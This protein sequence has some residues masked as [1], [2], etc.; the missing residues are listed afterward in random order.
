MD[1]A[2]DES[3]NFKD[4]WA[5]D[6]DDSP[7]PVRGSGEGR[8]TSAPRQS[9][10]ARTTGATKGDGRAARAGADFD[11]EAR[12]APRRRINDKPPSGP[13]AV[14]ALL[15]CLAV[16]ALVVTGFIG[17]GPLAG[18]FFFPGGTHK[19]V[20]ATAQG[21]APWEVRSDDVTFIVVGPASPFIPKDPVDHAR[22]I[23]VT[24]EYAGD[25]LRAP[26]VAMS[27]GGVSLREDLGYSQR[28]EG[29]KGSE[30]QRA[31]VVFMALGDQTPRKVTVS[32]RD[33]F[34]DDARN[35]AVTDVPVR[36]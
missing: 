11:D 16:L 20:S 17:R 27:D 21:K 6:D 32:L 22:R 8:H 15:V 36:G 2:R 29:T 14:V 18:R 12:L 23:A 7:P 26:S 25:D 35:L 4:P 13:G 3:P 9:L 24:V 19:T 30:R 33:F 10:D 34:W 5:A 31:T 1:D 28:T